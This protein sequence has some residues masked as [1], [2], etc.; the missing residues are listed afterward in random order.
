MIQCNENHTDE[1]PL[2][3]VRLLYTELAQN[4]EMDFGWGKGK[5][6]ARTLGYPDEWLSH[7]PDLVW[8][9]IVVNRRASSASRSIIAEQGRDGSLYEHVCSS[10]RFQARMTNPP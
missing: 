10:R 5:E 2:E 7:L 9:S 3:L 1:N 4:P 8:S 6:N